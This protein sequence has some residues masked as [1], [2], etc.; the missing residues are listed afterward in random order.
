MD[1]LRKPNKDDRRF[2]IKLLIEEQ[3]DS[4]SIIELLVQRG[5]TKDQSEGLIEQIQLNGEQITKKQSNKAMMSGMA[6]AG[7]GLFMFL[8]DIGRVGF[9][10][11][12]VGVLLF[13]RGLGSFGK[14]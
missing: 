10:L 1:A 5:L 9:G 8:A 4:D 2:A 6:L 11:M 14:G 7:I 3:I 13:M 12:I